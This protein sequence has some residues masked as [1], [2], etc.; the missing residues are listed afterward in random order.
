MKC[1]GLGSNME[2]RSPKSR[3]N[4]VK[5]MKLAMLYVLL[6][7]GHGMNIFIAGGTKK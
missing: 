5:S 3:K 4:V 7:H 1:C 6:L 2:T